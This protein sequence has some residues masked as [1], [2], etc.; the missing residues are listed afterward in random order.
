M[1]DYMNKGNLKQILNNC[2]NLPEQIIKKIAYS[3]IEALTI[4]QN[5]TNKCY[6]PIYPTQVLF[7]AEEKIKVLIILILKA[8]SKF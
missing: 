5:T 3:L 7:D 6:G 1:V 4:F 2:G 8:K